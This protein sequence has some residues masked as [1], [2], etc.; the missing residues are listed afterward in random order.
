MAPRI[1]RATPKVAPPEPKLMNDGLDLHL[2]GRFGVPLR[3][4]T[5]T[6]STN[7]QA[8]AWAAEGAPEGAVV[9]AD[10]QTAGRGRH[11]RRWAGGARRNLLFSAVLRPRLAPPLLGRLTLAAGVGVGRAVE[12]LTG[13]PAGLKW[14]NDVLVSGRKI[15]GILTEATLQAS[16]LQAAVVGVGLNTHWASDEIPHDLAGKVTSLAIELGDDRVSERVEILARVLVHLEAA[17][18]LMHDDAAALL[19]EVRRRSSILGRTVRVSH[20]NGRAET[21]TARAILDDGA[22]E[23]EVDGCIRAVHAADVERLEPG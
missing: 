6:D 1:L 11:G 20:T 9:V 15:A 13:S 7:T 4:L 5:V 23:V 3:H 19:D 8:L 17:Y 14:P 18:D 2:E 12:E 16:S 10:E 21:G 22:L